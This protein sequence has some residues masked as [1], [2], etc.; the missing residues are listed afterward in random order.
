MLLRV[1]NQASGVCLRWPAIVPEVVPRGR[2]FARDVWPSSPV[3]TGQRVCVCACACACACV[4]VA[5]V[6]L[7]SPHSSLSLHEGSNV[8]K[9]EEDIQPHSRLTIIIADA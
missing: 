9:N 4:C 3:Y 7:S 5:I 1:P 2:G 8:R 6:V